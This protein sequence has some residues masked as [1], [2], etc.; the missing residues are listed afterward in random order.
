MHFPFN[1]LELSNRLLALENTL[2][3]SGGKRRKIASP[4]EQT[5]NEFGRELFDIL[6]DGDVRGRFDG[7]MA[8]ANRRGEPLRIKLRF[9]SP[10]LS[11]LPWEFL[12]DRR[13]RDYLVLSANTPLV[14]YIEV[15]D[16]IKP[17]TVKAPLRMLG[18]VASPSDLD[19]LDV[20]RERERIEAATADLRMRGLLE[21]HWLERGTYRELQQTL[22]RRG[23]SWHVFHFAGHGGFDPKADEGL[24][25]FVDDQGLADR[26]PATELGR[27]LG[28][29]KPLRLAVLNACEGARGSNHDLFSSTAAT[30]VRRGTPAVVAMQYEITD[31][32]AKEFSRSFY[33][34]IADNLPVEIAMA[35][36]RKSLS[37][38]IPNTLEWGTPVL[39]M[40]SDD[41]VLFRVRPPKAL[42]PT[43]AATTPGSQLEP[44]AAD[45]AQPHPATAATVPAGTA[46]AGEPTDGSEPADGSHPAGASLVPRATAPAAAV[47]APA[48]GSL[49]LPTPVVPLT[50]PAGVDRL[51]S[52]VRNRAAI[53]AIVVVAIA[54]GALGGRFVFGLGGDTPQPSGS[55][56]PQTASAAPSVDASSSQP[57]PSNGGGGTKGT[58]HIALELVK[59]D[60]PQSRGIIDAVELA[61]KD[62]GGETGG[63]EIDMPRSL[64]LYDDGTPRVGADNMTRIV[65]RRDVVAVI[66]PYSS[67]VASAQIPL[68]NEAGLFQCSPSAT[69]PDLTQPAVRSARPTS[70]NFVRTVTTGDVEGP[71][72]ARF[73]IDKLGKSRVYVIDNAIASA[74]ARTNK[75]TEALEGRGGTV[76]GRQ[77]VPMTATDLS[78]IVANARSLG[79]EVIYFSGGSTGTSA[80]A[81]RLLKD[82]RQ[83]MPDTPFVASGE[84]FSDQAPFLSGAGSSLNSDV[85][86]VFPAVGEYPGRVDFETRY[87]REY[88]RAPTL[89]IASAFACTQ[90][91]L[92]AIQRADSTDRAA[93][94]ERV[95]AAAVDPLATY[96]TLIGDFH[97]DANGDTSQQIVT[98]YQAD[99]GINGWVLNQA[100]DVAR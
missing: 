64:I 63:W 38:E 79:A 87:R 94:R 47:A 72:A 82:V 25:A 90:V 21:L 91:L 97:F 42:P 46:V 53:A 58:L 23:Q 7:S 80:F 54:G 14:R 67:S 74:T 100:L 69:S 77:S 48:P 73:I 71:G 50:Q 3:R 86:A 70:I 4:E 43:A 45:T 88:G 1:D 11:A 37:H 44:V 85:Y 29:H 17:L 66:G 19:E 34:A 76:A 13:G 26:V 16:S 99:P 61:I 41:G 92:D 49:V 60:H 20:K 28:D 24:V 32:A 8:E 75:F 95:R 55:V 81:A 5:V 84:T 59:A 22:R 57:S 30:L 89:Y 62:A 56:P 12:F 65:A 68:S 2:L 31:D 15:A 78:A 96:R 52:L 33:E 35:E 9:D 18:M 10:T 98:I 51:R 39:F 83:A 36:A 93:M 27:L 6:I 40:R